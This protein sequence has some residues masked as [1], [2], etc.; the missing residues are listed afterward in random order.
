MEGLCVSSRG[1]TSH[2][3]QGSIWPRAL[4]RP[5]CGDY[6]RPIRPWRI[7]ANVLVVA[8]LELGHPMALFVL[9][10]A[11]DPSIHVEQGA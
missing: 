10:E 2:L 5:S 4:A 11:H 9:V 7:V 1:F 6:P 3:R 8:A